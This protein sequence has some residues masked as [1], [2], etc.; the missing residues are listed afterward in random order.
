MKKG[1][2]VKVIAVDNLYQIGKDKKIWRKRLNLECGHSIIKLPS[3][4][5]TFVGK[6]VLCKKCRI[7]EKKEYEK[8]D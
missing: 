2:R 5:S 4:P 1:E 3:L 8:I 6:E 7:E